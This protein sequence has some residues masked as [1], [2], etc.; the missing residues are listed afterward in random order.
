MR[1]VV[2]TKIFYSQGRGSQKYKSSMSSSVDVF[3]V[4][5]HLEPNS[6]VLNVHFL[7]HTYSPPK[8]HRLPGVFRV[9]DW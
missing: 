1:E 5:S 2:F 3:K 9:H 7:I 4:L 8:L 6:R